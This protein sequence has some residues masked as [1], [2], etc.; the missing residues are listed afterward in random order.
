MDNVRFKLNENVE[1][2]ISM[3]IVSIIVINFDKIYI[4]NVYKRIMLIRLYFL[5]INLKKIILISFDKN[6]VLIL[7]LN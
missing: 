6:S 2:Q 1:E 7:E 3:I 4:I 5:I